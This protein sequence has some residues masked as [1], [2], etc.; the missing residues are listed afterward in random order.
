MRP[1]MIMPILDGGGAGHAAALGT[2]TASEHEH[3]SAPHQCA[4]N[5]EA[6]PQ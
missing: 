1:L 6:S 5:L 2:E 3:V 4:M